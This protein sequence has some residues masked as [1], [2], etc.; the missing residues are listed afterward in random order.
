MYKIWNVLVMSRIPEEK[1]WRNYFYRVSL[2]CQANE[3]NS[4]VQENEAATSSAASSKTAEQYKGI[5]V[6][7]IY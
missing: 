2:I 5:F 7:H 4:M 6:F 3:L 1:F